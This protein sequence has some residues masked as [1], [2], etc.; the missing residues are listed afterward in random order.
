MSFP[1][2]GMR[3]ELKG[4]LNK[5]Y[6]SFIIPALNEEDNISAALV[7]IDTFCPHSHEVIVVDH[8]STD[9]TRDIAMSLGASVIL[10]PH[11][12]IGG[13]RNVGAHRASGDILVFIDADV[14]L[15]SEWREGIDL[16]FDRIAAGE[17]LL[18]GSHC[19]PPQSN[20]L[21]LSFW[22]KGLATDPR[23]THIGTGHMII[24]RQNFIDLNGF[25]PALKTGED[26]E[27]C[28][29]AANKGYRIENQ[30]KLKVVHA[31]F[32]CA[33]FD[34]MRR[35]AWHGRSDFASWRAFMSSKVAVMTAVF[36]LLHLM[37]L[38][39]GK[40][41]SAAF[42][43]LLIVLFFSSFIKYRHLGVKGIIINSGIFYFYFWGRIG[44]FLLT[45][46]E[47]FGK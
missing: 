33:L 19:S 13:L 41:T 35:E 20:N 44:S 28:S 2:Q 15:T 14:V 42:F 39:G 17:R 26:Y 16:V 25:D 27:L 21:L 1:K 5:Y 10:H 7:S 23:N 4:Q 12:T 45:T 31:D 40:I 47:K 43:S 22:F 8:G 18:S 36:F 37:M 11:G 9:L 24:S 29:R 3:W 6:V 46:A 30:H 32:P 34:F 38:V